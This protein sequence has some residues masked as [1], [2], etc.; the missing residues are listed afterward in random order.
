M[1]DSKQRVEEYEI[2][3]RNKLFR[4]ETPLTNCEEWKM[5]TKKIDRFWLKKNF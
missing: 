2:M 4:A 1:F 5:P 3:L